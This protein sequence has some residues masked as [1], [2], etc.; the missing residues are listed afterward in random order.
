MLC[1]KGFTT[2]HA[3]RRRY[4]GAPYALYCL[5]LCQPYWGLRW[6]GVSRVVQQSL[7][8]PLFDA[9]R[10]KTIIVIACGRLDV[11]FGWFGTF[12]HRHPRIAAFSKR[13]GLRPTAIDGSSSVMVIGGRS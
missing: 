4:Y 12:E 13:A 11:V 8:M 10:L 7:F 1:F 5:N 3:A 2:N 9:P 6:L